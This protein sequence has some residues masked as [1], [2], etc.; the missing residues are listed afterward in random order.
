MIRAISVLFGF[1]TI[2]IALIAANFVGQLSLVG[3]TL[4]ISAIICFAVIAIG[5]T[6]D[7]DVTD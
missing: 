4:G 6:E 2:V 5:W 1:P 3:T 7:H